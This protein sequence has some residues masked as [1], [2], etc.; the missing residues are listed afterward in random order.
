MTFKKDVVAIVGLGY[1][2]LPIAIE[3]G[4]YYKT[5][6]FDV[7]KRKINQ[8]KKLIDVN[9][10]IDKKQ[11]L[12]SK[13]LEFTYSAKKLSQANIIIVAVPTP[14][15]SAK[16]PDLSYLKS[17]SISV[18][19][20]MKKNCIVV[21]ESTVYPGVTEDFCI[22][23]LE[24]NSGLSW[25]KDFFV[26]YSPERIN[27]GDKKRTLVNIIKVVS[28]DTKKTALILE[29]LYNKII[30]AGVFVAESIKVAEAAKVIE[31]TQRDINIALM[32]ELSLIFNKMDINTSSVLE[33]ANTKWNFQNFKPGL[34]G[35]HCIGVDPY[36]LL[37]KAAQLGIHTEVI[38]SG[39][40]TN[41]YMSK[42]VSDNV[43]KDLAKRNIKI[44]EARILILG[45]TFKENVSD[46]RN[47]KMIEIYKNLESYGLNIFAY[48]PYVNATELLTEF[49]IKMHDI[50]TIS[51]KVDAIIYG[52]S[53]KIFKKINDK[54]LKR[55]LSDEG[56]I[57]DI[58][59]NLDF[60]SLAKSGIKIWQL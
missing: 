14:I 22:P 3:F 50:N 55:L 5:I 11:F 2:G 34:V 26:G 54:M 9:K 59:S 23:I 42:Y 25:K 48:D 52:V 58:Q 60:K 27:P 29:K 44:G 1:V 10:E 41:D 36:Y 47:S 8:Y 39:R 18:A 31:N 28:G 21:Y 38:Q 56:V 6:G 43:T 49:N 30:K 35:G 37:Y 53:H 12:S 40:K 13:H 16:K 51:K 15:D 4:K 45:L 17:S 57:Y 7:S 24:K 19:R 32:N 20:N 33:A 46:I